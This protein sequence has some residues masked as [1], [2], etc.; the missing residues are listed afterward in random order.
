[1]TKTHVERFNKGAVLEDDYVP[2]E[3]LD[4][5]LELDTEEVNSRKY[6][7]TNEDTQSFEDESDYSPK[8]SNERV[9]DNR[10]SLNYRYAPQDNRTSL[11]VDNNTQVYQPQ[12]NFY[13]N[14]L[15]TSYA[16]EYLRF[17][18]YILHETMKDE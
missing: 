4:L 16:V 14:G 6:A 10:S 17:L 1:M 2:L 7:P 13:V 18:K 12:T 5:S 9:Y 15:F 8:S 3:E 11:Y